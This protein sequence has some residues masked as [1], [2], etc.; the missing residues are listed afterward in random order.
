MAVDRTAGQVHVPRRQARGPSGSPAVQCRETA[1][2]TRRS[3]GCGARLLGHATQMEVTARYARLHGRG[4]AGL[5]PDGLGRGWTTGGRG[6][7]W[8]SRKVDVEKS[9]RR[10]KHALSMRHVRRMKDGVNTRWPRPLQQ[11]R[12][13]N[14]REKKRRISPLNPQASKGG[15]RCTTS[16][17]RR[18]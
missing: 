2:V 1:A 6:W 16:D 13:S 8:S 5:L 15:S 18:P 10:R 4:V 17:P 9:G 12:S 11:R 14:G 3:G 7:S